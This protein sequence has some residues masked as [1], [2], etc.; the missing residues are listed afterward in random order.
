MAPKGGRSASSGGAGHT[1]DPMLS[2][3]GDEVIFAYTCAV[4]YKFDRGLTRRA[5]ASSV[6]VL[7]VESMKHDLDN[8]KW[9]R[10][11]EALAQVASFG[12][13]MC[14]CEL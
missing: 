8:S 12:Q 13:H 7:G 14:V 2:E 3:L 9:T 11:R 1:A 5:H 4:A 10:L 6:V